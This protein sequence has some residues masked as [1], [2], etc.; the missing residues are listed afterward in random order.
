MAHGKEQFRSAVVSDSR[1]QQLENVTRRIVIIRHVRTRF[2]QPTQTL[3]ERQ[4][5]VVRCFLVECHLLYYLK[6]FVE[7][8]DSH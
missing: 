5:L 3:T 4:K 2:V 8:S 1:Q 6:Q 7:M